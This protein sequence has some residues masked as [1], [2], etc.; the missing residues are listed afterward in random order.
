RLFTGPGRRPGP[1]PG[2]TP[3]TFHWTGSETR[4]PHPVPHPRL[5]TG[6]GR[7]PRFHTSTP[8]LDR[9]GDPVPHPVPHLDFSPDRVGDPVPH[10]V[11]H[12]VPQRDFARGRLGII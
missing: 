6:P 9:V 12:P 2:P 10:P 11:P 7:R 5:F 1:T 3:S 4:F 8:S